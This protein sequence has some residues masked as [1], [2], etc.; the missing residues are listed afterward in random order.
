MTRLRFIR[1][2]IGFAGILVLGSCATQPPPAESGPASREVQA[3]LDTR[4]TAIRSRTFAAGKPIVFRSVIS[5]IEDL[6][7]SVHEADPNTGII[8]AEG[9]VEGSAAAS[10]GISRKAV[11]TAVVEQAGADVRVILNFAIRSQY[12]GAYGRAA[13][14]TTSVFETGLTDDSYSFSF[15]TTIPS[16]TQ[17]RWYEESVLDAG[18]YRNAFEQI[19]QAVRRS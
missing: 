4:E 12:S 17:P 16:E 7:Y 10:S 18:V 11:A 14:E 6:G 19:E 3:P 13:P 15:T 1:M 8:T 9:A 2:G 5:V